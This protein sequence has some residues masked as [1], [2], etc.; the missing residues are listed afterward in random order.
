M[1]NRFIM[2]TANVLPEETPVDTSPDISTPGA[3][4]LIIVLMII[5]IL[6][7]KGKKK[8]M[9]LCEA[10]DKKEYPFKSMTMIGFA[11]MEMI[12]YKYKSN[13][14][15]KLRRVLRELKEEEYVEFYLRATW[16]TAATY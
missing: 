1:L 13:L 15:R 14:D 2:L 4:Y 10:L 16:A 12:K 6:Y 9:P 8:Y 7:S 3:I 11:F 5:V